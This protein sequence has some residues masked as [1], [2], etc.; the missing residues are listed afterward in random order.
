L[1]A[2]YALSSLAEINGD[3]RQAAHLHRKALRMAEELGLWPEVSLHLSG[4]GRIALLI[5][6]YTHAEEL[7]KQAMRL[8]AEQGYKPS[9]VFAEV[10]LGLGARKQG[11]LEIAERHMRN[12][13]DWNRRMNYQPG[14]AQALAELGFIAEQRGDADAA[15]ALHRDSFA[16]ARQTGDARA[17]ALALEG[18]AGAQALTGHHHRAARLL[19]TA[20]AVRESVGAALPSAERG[21]VD[22][23]AAKA[24][25]KLGTDAFATEFQRGSGLRLRPVVDRVRDP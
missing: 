13:L 15:R 6:N 17:L 5:G 7:H 22:R 8:A 21:D 10:G 1:Q 2:T 12:V 9:E 24:R 11:K 3:Y 23:I 25:A 4:L 19:G 20:A 14:V 18:L 16:I